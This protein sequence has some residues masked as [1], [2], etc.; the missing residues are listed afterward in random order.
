M[1]FDFS[2]VRLSKLILVVFSL[3]IGTSLA[4]IIQYSFQG[5]LE[6]ITDDFNFIDDEFTVGTEFYGIFSYSTEAVEESSYI[7]DDS[8]G[9]YST[10]IH[11]EVIIGGYTLHGDSSNSSLGYLQI[12]DNRI[13][14]SSTVDAFTVASPLDFKPLISGMGPGNVI[15]QANINFFDFSSTASLDGIVIPS[16]INIS[17]FNVA[18]FSAIQLN[19]T[20]Q[21]VFH[22]NGKITSLTLTK[23]PEPSTF[24]LLSLA[25]LGFSVSKKSNPSSPI[26]CNS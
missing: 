18:S 20:T 21:E 10:I 25:L 1:S 16:V 24:I 4:G 15:T 19:T 13:V 3:N 22:L 7:N 26:S 14:G 2:L 5:E 9:I 6:R 23:V 12:W 17:D 11:L 8:I